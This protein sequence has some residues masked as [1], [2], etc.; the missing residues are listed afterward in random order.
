MDILFKLSRFGEVRY[1]QQLNRF[2]QFV[3]VFGIWVSFVGQMFAQPIRGGAS[4]IDITPPIGYPMWGYAARHDTPSTGVRDRLY[5]RIAILEVGTSRVAIVGLDL[6]RAPMRDSMERIREQL[7]PVGVGCV[8]LVASHTHHGPILELDSWPNRTT[9]YVRQLEKWL[10]QGISEAA[11]KCEPIRIKFAGE[12]I[13]GNR[14]RQSKQQNPPVDQQLNVIVLE[15]IKTGKPVAHLVN[16]PAHPTMLPAKLN[17]FSPDFPGFMAK[18]VQDASGGVCV[19]L[20]GASGDLSVN[21]QRG[22]SPE[23]FGEFLANEVLRVEKQAQ[24]LRSENVMLKWNRDEFRFR[25]RTSVTNPIFQLL[26]GRAFFPELVGAF[27]REYREG[28]RP[29][30]TTLLINKQIGMV[31]VSGELF[32]AHAIRLRERAKIPMLMVLGCTN[33]YQQY[34][35]TIESVAEGGYGTEVPVAMAEVGAG[36]RMMDRALMRIHQLLGRLSELDFPEK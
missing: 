12:N 14:N 19:Y 9:P 30:M 36:E 8:L 31:A 35:P 13:P 20:Q 23:E 16:F 33:G 2:F 17:E 5:A 24:P 6:G 25:P 4:I 1:S 29:E 18:K 28:V 21:P 34:F 11:Q 15:S 3:F 7:K 27:E 10:V 22:R 32:S 26:V